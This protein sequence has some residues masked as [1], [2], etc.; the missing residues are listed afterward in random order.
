MI[1]S[2]IMAFVT[3]YLY[4]VEN[5]HVLQANRFLVGI[6]VGLN[7]ATAQIYLKERM[8][9]RLT[10]LG[11]MII[12]TS[13]VMFVLLSFSLGNFVSEATLIAQ[14]RLIFLIPMPIS[15]IRTIYLCFVSMDTPKFYLLGADFE[16][17]KSKAL[18]SLKKIF[19]DKSAR[20]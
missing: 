1:F 17:G 2:E 19:D 14:W 5:L 18:A 15:V 20:Q 6:V 13:L 4:T 3:Y 12:Y 8:P 16:V 9:K 11:G 10:S 7:T